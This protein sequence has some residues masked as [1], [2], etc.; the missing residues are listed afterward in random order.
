MRPRLLPF[1][2][3]A[4]L[5]IPMLPACGSSASNPWT[6]PGGSSGGSS[7]GG[8]GVGGSIPAGSNSSGS[9]SGSS[10]AGAG[11]SGDNGSGGSISSGDGSDGGPGGSSP[12][13][14]GDA[15][16]DDLADSGGPSGSSPE[17]GAADD[18]GGANEGS[19]PSSDGGG[20]ATADL[21]VVMYL[22]NWSGSYSSWAKKIDFNKMTHLLLAFGTVTGTSDW[23]LGANDPDVQALAAAAHAHNVK[24]LVSIGGADGDKSIINAYADASNV[25]PLVANLDSTVSSLH[26]DGVDVDLERGSMMKSSSNY[27]A[28]VKQLMSTFHPEGKLVTS[29]LAQYIVEDANA[30]A[31]II[32]VVNS[33]DFI[34]DM[35]YTTKMS[36][37]TSESNWWTSTV[38]LPKNKLVWGVDFEGSSLTVSTVTQI[39]TASKA[40]GGIMAWEYTQPS[41]AQLWPAI[42]GVF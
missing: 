29:A 8:S 28:F 9:S 21:K 7:S 42:Q 24:V 13:A 16:A 41:E 31:T 35:V 3:I 26:L 12:E 34:N 22:P 5:M 27:P 19:A 18:G 40:Y 33:F 11:S 10:S 2:T 39:A 37:F 6:A 17:A 32:G 23:D 36:D 20:A 15:G 4:M 38:K 14:G 30:D 25:A 1:R